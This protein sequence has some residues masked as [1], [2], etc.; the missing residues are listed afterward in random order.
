MCALIYRMVSA[1]RRLSLSLSVTGFVSVAIP[2][3]SGT[4][5]RFLFLSERE[6]FKEVKSALVGGDIRS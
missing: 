2:V 3:T 1:S 6:V 5:L 4:V